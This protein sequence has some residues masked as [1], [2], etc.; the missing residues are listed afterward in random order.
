V[1]PLARHWA[2]AS[3]HDRFVLLKRAHDLSDQESLLL[4]GWVRNYEELGLAHQLK[5]D[6]FRI[7]CAF[8][9]T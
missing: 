9:R 2:C 4:S 8:Q 3:L 7:Y 1:H 5:E 6:F